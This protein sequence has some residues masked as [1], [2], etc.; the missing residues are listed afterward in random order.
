[1]DGDEFVSAEIPAANG[2][3]GGTLK[4]SLLSTI[5]YPD[6]IVSWALF[7][8]RMKSQIATIPSAMRVIPARAPPTAAAMFVPTLL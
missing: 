2:V 3:G 7:R 6:I 8:R 5:G 1:M 4:S